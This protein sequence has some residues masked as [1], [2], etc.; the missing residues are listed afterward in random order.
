[1]DAGAAKELMAYLVKLQSSLSE[2]NQRNGCT[3][4][5]EN[6]MIR[7]ESNRFRKVMVSSSSCT[8]GLLWLTSC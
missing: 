4:V 3:G 6:N 7:L 2:V 1:M 5:L 8:N